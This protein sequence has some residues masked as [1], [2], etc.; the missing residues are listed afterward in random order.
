MTDTTKLQGPHRIDTE[1]AAGINKSEPAA[2]ETRGPLWPFKAENCS[3]LS[4][5][6]RL[7]PD[8]LRKPERTLVFSIVRGISVLHGSDDLAAAIRGNAA[9]AIGAA[10]ELMPIGEVT[11]QV[12]ITLTALLRIA[13]DGDAAS[14]LVMAQIIGLSDIGHHFATELAASWLDYG[15]RL[16]KEPDT[17]RAARNTLLTA[18]KDDL[19]KGE[20]AC[21]SSV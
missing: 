13:L 20:D 17:F 5:W 3:P 8:A 1:S 21:V 14:A 12:D 2:N 18:F 7:P 15:E 11:L 19:N 16:S 9:A 4:W 10:L 6:R